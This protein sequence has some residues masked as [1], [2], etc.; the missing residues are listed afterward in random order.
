MR[1]VLVRMQAIGVQDCS[2]SLDF[3]QANP[4]EST[5]LFNTILVTV[6][7]FLRGSPTW[8]FL[9]ELLPRPLVPAVILTMEETDGAPVSASTSGARYT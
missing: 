8:D 2:A 7:S 6:T 4:E 1:R 9:R 5:R 3:L